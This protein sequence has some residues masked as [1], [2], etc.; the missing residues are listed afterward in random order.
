MK[1]ASGSGSITGEPGYRPITALRRVP[2]RR[3]LAAALCGVLLGGSGALAADGDPTPS[4]SPDLVKQANAPISSILQ[5]RL[6]NSYVPKFTGV[7]GQGNTFSVAVTMPLP[8]F[9]LL[10]V[11]QLSLLTLPAA[12]TVPS[13]LTGVGD[14]RFVDI[15]VMDAGHDILWGVGPTVVFPTASQPTTG[16]GKWQVGPAAAI[17]FAPKRWLIGVLAQ[18]PIS[19]GC[20]STR[21]RVNTLVLQPFLIYQFDHGWF[22]RSQPQLLFD[23]K[24]G[25]QILPID[26]GAGRVFSL[27]GQQLNC[28]VEGFWNLTH[29][30]PGPSYGF[31]VGVS[32]LY[33][34]FWER[35]NKKPAPAA[36]SAAHNQ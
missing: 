30:G 19:V 9:R 27:A 15:A 35:W 4:A 13:G 14:L 32:F 31:T 26:L 20:D 1:P 22:V 7:S 23:W 34:G 36:E 16:L 28:F 10:P 2:P 24:T 21:A 25:K 11:P 29:D 12:V 6:Q 18:N 3:W 33:P 8:E 17:A 5:V